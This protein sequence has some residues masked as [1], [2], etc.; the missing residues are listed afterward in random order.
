MP[1]MA[2]CI[3]V[4]AGLFTAA[5]A[6]G[7]AG[8]MLAAPIGSLEWFSERLDRSQRVHRFD[9]VYLEVVHEVW[10]LDAGRGE[11]AELARI[12]EGKPDHPRQEEYN[13]LLRQV[14][15]GPES[16]T[17][18]IWHS[19]ETGWRVSIDTTDPF[20]YFK[21]MDVASNGRSIWVLR[22]QV[23]S[24]FDPSSMPLDSDYSQD[25]QQ[26][27]RFIS[28]FFTSGLYFGRLGLRPDSSVLSDGAWRAEASNSDLGRRRQFQ[29]TLS[30]D[31]TSILLSTVI[32]SGS[33]SPD[34]GG[35]RFLYENWVENELAGIRVPSVVSNQASSGR[36]LNR[37]TLKA[38]RRASPLEIGSMVALP[39]PIAGHDKLRDISRVVE[40]RDARP[41]RGVAMTP[42]GEVI[43]RLS[44][45]E[46]GRFRGRGY[47]LAWALA[48][49]LVSGL[50][51]LRVRNGR[52]KRMRS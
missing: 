35:Q 46:T 52:T 18:R 36:P 28:R 22:D 7:A 27:D 43:G 14:S 40:V 42:D 2:G 31:G 38:F 11:L 15:F 25:I 12:V 39:D 23:L 10:A 33:G 20:M 1:G 4:I 9:D 13:K 6:S 44:I 29:G 19:N 51:F 49:L 17:Y 45:R 32:D 47:A 26:F 16:W 48:G 50:I 5:L 24:I 30:A 37:W 34:P 41:G 3:T 8:G 21:Y